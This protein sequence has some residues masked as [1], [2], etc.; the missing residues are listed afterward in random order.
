M[1]SLTV[2][3]VTLCITRNLFYLSPQKVN[4]DDLKIIDKNTFKDDCIQKHFQSLC[5][6]VK[7]SL[8]EEGSFR[9]LRGKKKGQDR[10][11]DPLPGPS[12]F[13]INL[14]KKLEFQSLFFLLQC[15]EINLFMSTQ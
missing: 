7:L 12:F 15:P 14:Q 3:P 11:E 13:Y 5:E 2:T 6:C 8:K 10:L 9:R 1:F 4:D